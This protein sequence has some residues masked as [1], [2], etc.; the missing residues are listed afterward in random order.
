MSRAH[1]G[2]RDAAELA[3]ML[4]LISD[5]RARPDTRHLAASFR[6]LGVMPRD[7]VPG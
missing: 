6:S 3:E 1:L 7:V 5:W 4:T 2:A